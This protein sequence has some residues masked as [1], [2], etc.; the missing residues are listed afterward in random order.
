MHQDHDKFVRA[1]EDRRKII[2]TYFSGEYSL[3]LTKLCVPL[4]YSPA[5]EE[6]DP[7]CYYLWD[8]EGDIGRRVLV[9]PSSRIV[10]MELSDDTFEP[11][12]YMIPEKQ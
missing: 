2:L 7:G 5:G 12:E 8:P 4:Q 3:N 1:N 10:Y 9:L 11:D 6:G